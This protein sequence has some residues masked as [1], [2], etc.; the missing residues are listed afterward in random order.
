MALRIFPIFCM[1]V[2]DNRAHCLS[3]IVFLK[4]FLIPNY[5]GLSVKKGG[6]FYF[7]ALYSK[8]ALRIFPII[9]MLV[10]DNRAHC[11]SKIVFLKKSLNPGLQGIKSPK[12]VFFDFFR[13]Y[14]KT[15]LRIFQIFCLSVEANSLLFEK[16]CFLEKIPNPELQVIKSFLL[17]CI[18]L[19]NGFKD[20]PTLF[21]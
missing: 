20:L 7:F 2:E 16:N 11:M 18:L 5:R 3:K 14:S 8:T 13:L 12:K 19:Q 4:K 15:G 17:I 9:W 6:V 21:A 10:K 1:S